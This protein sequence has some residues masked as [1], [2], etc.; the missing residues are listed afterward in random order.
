MEGANILLLCFNLTKL[1]VTSPTDGM[2]ST[3]PVNGYTIP[4]RGEGSQTWSRE[5]HTSKEVTLRDIDCGNDEIIHVIVSE[6]TDV[7]Y[8]GV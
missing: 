3:N 5:S 8:R 6:R 4:L 2:V 1:S 7:T